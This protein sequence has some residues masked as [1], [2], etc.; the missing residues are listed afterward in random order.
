MSLSE[1]APD[2][3]IDAERMTVSVTGGTSYGVLAAA[4]QDQGF[5]LHNMGSLPHI[6]VAGATATGTHGSGDGN[7][8]L[9]TA[10]SA[11]ELVTA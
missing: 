3:A 5:A 10:I 9:A 7:G 2:I 1:L 4:L 6:S 11:V 8:I